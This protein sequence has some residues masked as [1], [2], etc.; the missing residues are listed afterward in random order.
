MAH[1]SCAVEAVADSLPSSLEAQRGGATRVELCSALSTG[2]I[3]P[4]RALVD[5]SRKHL[6][7]PLLVLV[8]PREGDF[9]LD[10]L[11]LM[12]I[13]R[14]IEFLKSAGVDGIVFGALRPDGTVDQEST[15]M[16]V[17]A[18]APLPVTFHRA[19]DVCSNREEALEAIIHCGCKRVLTSGGSLSVAD[20]M[21][22]IRRSHVQSAG[23]ISIVAG[24]RLDSSHLSNLHQMGIREFHLSGRVPV[25]SPLNT[26]LYQMDYFE[27]SHSIIHGV[28]DEL[29]RICRNAI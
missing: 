2:G 23:R 13:C 11:E 1:H 26:N 10:E 8:R 18:A 14:E 4:S 27:T 9:V 15:K 12:L 7:I 6:R 19:F 17:Q 3:T 21:E 5:M 28:V 22:A 25:K 16:I 24:G 29:N 20:G